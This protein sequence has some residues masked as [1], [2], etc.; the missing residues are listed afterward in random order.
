MG[1]LATVNQRLQW[2]IIELIAGEYD[3][4]L[5][6]YDEGA[7]LSS[8]SRYS[9]A[10]EHRGYRNIPFRF[11]IGYQTSPF[12]PYV[13]SISTFTVGSG[14]NINKFIFD[15]VKQLIRKQVQEA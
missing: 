5:N 3:V 2:D 9:L 7:L 14:I 12:K 15:F 11:G 1:V 8:F 10:I 13:S 4:E 6:K